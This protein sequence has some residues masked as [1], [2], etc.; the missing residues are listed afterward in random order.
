MVP[1]VVDL[2]G[3][4]IDATGLAASH[5]VVVGLVSVQATGAG[6]GVVGVDA[7]SNSADG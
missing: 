7:V 3:M 4:E 1:Q 2:G 5:E 6:V